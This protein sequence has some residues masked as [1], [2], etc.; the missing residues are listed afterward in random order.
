MNNDVS[1]SEWSALM[2]RNGQNEKQI[3]EQL[4]L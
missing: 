4:H 1:I 3:T 2:E